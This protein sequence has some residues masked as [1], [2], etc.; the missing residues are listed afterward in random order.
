MFN[1]AWKALFISKKRFKYAINQLL[2]ETKKKKLKK[3]RDYYNKKLGL[4]NSS[5]H[6]YRVIVDNNEDF[7][8]KMKSAEIQCGIH[9]RCTHNLKAYFGK[10]CN[11]YNLKQSEMAEKHIASIPFREDLTNKDQQYIVEQV[12]KCQQ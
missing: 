2:I 4:N 11:T 1:S 10:T 3:I 8:E 7:I 6:L 5:D 12:K 9:Y